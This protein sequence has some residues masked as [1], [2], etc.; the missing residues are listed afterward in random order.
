MFY[1]IGVFFVPIILL[2]IFLIFITLIGIYLGI[3][4]V[5][6]GKKEFSYNH[7][8]SI[9]FAKKLI[10]WGVIIYVIYTLFIE[11][12]IRSAFFD[13]PFIDTFIMI[14]FWLALV[15]IIK[16]L[17][18][19]KIRK[20]LWIAFYSRFLIFLLASITGWIFF[21]NLNI[22]YLSLFWII[23]FIPTLLYVYCYYT[24]YKILKN[25]KEAFKRM[26]SK[27]IICP[28][29]GETQE[30]QGFLGKKATVS[31]KKCKTEGVFHFR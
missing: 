12:S 17:T 8:K 30:V 27:T 2:V 5:Y 19:D 16:E 25:E 24:T 15:Y 14:P 13:I 1:I 18:Y 20:L 29:C 22:G 4:N 11:P 26:I 23:G 3:R 7:E 9:N 31:C 21:S 10:K 6:T 28:S